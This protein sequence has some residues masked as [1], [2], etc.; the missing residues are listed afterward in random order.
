LEKS[1]EQGMRTLDRDLFELYNDGPIG[2]E[3]TM[4]DA[5]LVKQQ[6]RK[7]ELVDQELE[8]EM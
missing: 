2:W 1:R 4:R 6:P 5:E 7:R 3:E 8:K